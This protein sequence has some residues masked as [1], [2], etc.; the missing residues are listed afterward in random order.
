MWDERGS[1]APYPPVEGRGPRPRSLRTCRSACWASPL[2]SSSP[3]KDWDATLPRVYVASEWSNEECR[4]GV[5]FTAS[6]DPRYV[7]RPAR[8]R[9]EPA[10]G[11]IRSE[12][13][14]LT[15]AYEPFEGGR[16]PESLRERGGR[17][18]SKIGNED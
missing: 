5:R 12:W 17:P 18:P 16:E 13:D 3:G 9:E 14:E 11:D 1:R 15:E 6:G 10:H 8:P 2:S 7:D 4:L